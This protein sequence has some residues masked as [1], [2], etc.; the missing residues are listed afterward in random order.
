MLDWSFAK[1]A[2]AVLSVAMIGCGS[3]VMAQDANSGPPE[4]YACECPNA[5]Q[6][7]GPSTTDGLGSDMAEADTPQTDLNLT[8]DAVKKDVEQ[9]LEQRGNP[10]LKVGEVKEKDADTIE[11]EI[12]T[13]DNSLVER[14]AVDRHSGA[15]RPDHGAEPQNL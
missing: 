13:L 11:A 1:S 15:Y 5:T 10:R 14:Y 7:Y 3:A 2:A 12:V 6:G 4:G 9:W 8:V